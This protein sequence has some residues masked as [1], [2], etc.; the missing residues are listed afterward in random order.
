MNKLMFSSALRQK[1]ASTTVRIV[2]INDLCKKLSL[3]CNLNTSSLRAYAQKI[4]SILQGIVSSTKSPYQ[5]LL[6]IVWNNY[7]LIQQKVIASWN[8]TILLTEIET[9][10]KPTLL[11]VLPVDEMS[12]Q[13]IPIAKL[14]A[15]VSYK[16]TPSMLSVYK[17]SNQPTFIAQLKVSTPDKPIPLAISAN[18][19]SN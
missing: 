10:N 14:R 9:P 15:S 13:P 16:I 4:I 18:K 19:M 1:L 17:V 7:F 2:S 6:P 3:V 8:C 12:N 11:L 5:N